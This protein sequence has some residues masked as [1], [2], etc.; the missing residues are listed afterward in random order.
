MSKPD[1]KRTIISLDIKYD[2]LMSILEKRKTPKQICAELKI[3][4]CTVSSWLKNKDNIIEQYQ[5]SSTQT[6]CKKVKNA[7][8]LEIDKALLEW[9]QNLRGNKIKINGP[10]MMAK[11]DEFAAYFNINF[12]CNP[13]WLQRFK[14]R[15]NISWQ[16]KEHGEAA[17]VD[18]KIVQDWLK[19]LEEICKDYKDEDIFNADETGLFYQLQPSGTMKFKHESC[20]GGKQSKVRMSLLLTAS[21]LGEKLMPLVVAKSEN[22]RCFKNINKNNLGVIYRAYSKSWMTGLIF[23]NW[24]KMIDKKFKHE[25]RKILLFLDNFSGHNITASLTNITVKFYPPNCTSV[26]QPLDQGII[27]NFKH[28]YRSSI[29]KSI[30]EN[31]D[32]DLDQSL[33]INVKDSIDR[34]VSAWS[35]V[36]PSTITHCFQ[37]A[38]IKLKCEIQSAVVVEPMS[39]SQNTWSRIESTN[40]FGYDDYLNIDSNLETYA[41]VDDAT[42]VSNILDM[43]QP[44]EENEE[45]TEEDL[46]SLPPIP[47]NKE[48]EDSIAKLRLWL[49]SQKTDTNCHLRSINQFQA[50]IASLMVNN[51]KQTVIKNYFN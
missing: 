25:N 36:K 34:I 40:S 48:V 9:F 2:A 30:I 45:E 31:I 37:K 47:S 7:Q 18:K 41:P 5:S 22:P 26:I 50:D 14:N 15:H 51:L 43:P 29:I 23:N 46:I 3:N 1:I 13:G 42:I 33:T 20:I 44:E 4:H 39:I 16:G 27:A 28:H 21:V 8:H 35:E 32:N 6:F 24:L 38:G 17:S 19:Q 10:I 49:Q 11:A 12:K